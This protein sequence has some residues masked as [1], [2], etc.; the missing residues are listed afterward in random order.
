MTERDR[1]EFAVGL[2]GP[3]QEFVVSSSRFVGRVF[4]VQDPAV[5]AQRVAAVRRI[6]HDATHHAWAYR[7]GPPEEP[8]ERFDDDG[9]PSGSAG[10]PLLRAIAGRGWFDTLVVVTRWFGGVKLGTGGLARAYGEAARLA[11]VAAP[12]EVR[13]RTVRM[14]ATCGF[15]DLGAVEAALAR[16]AHDV[17]RVDRSFEP[18]PRFAIEARRS[19]ADALRVAILD[20]TAGR[21][22]VA[23]V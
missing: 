10:R 3:E 4:A 8:R 11:L 18:G 21:A 1:D 2:D 22:K 16:A 14:H 15:E 9:E 7:L 12:V 23:P 6:L 17:A 5:A 13:L 19:G 20:A